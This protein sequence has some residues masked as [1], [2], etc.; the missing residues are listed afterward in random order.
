[1]RSNLVGR[2][3]PLMVDWIYMPSFLSAMHLRPESISLQVAIMSVPVTET[4]P[5]RCLEDG[6]KSIDILQIRVPTIIVLIG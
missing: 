4:R 5:S 1:M 6:V 3:A 2:L